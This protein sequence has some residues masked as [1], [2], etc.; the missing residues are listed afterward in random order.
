MSS[1]IIGLIVLIVGVVVSIFITPKDNP[2]KNKKPE[3]RFG[4]DVYSGDREF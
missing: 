2:L 1:T 3:S 4:V